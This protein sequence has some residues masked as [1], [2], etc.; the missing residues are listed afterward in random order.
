MNNNGPPGSCQGVLYDCRVFFTLTEYSSF[1]GAR[2]KRHT[3]KAPTYQHVIRCTALGTTVDTW[4]AE[5]RCPMNLQ[6]LS[7]SVLVI[8]VVTLLMILGYR[9][10]TGATDRETGKGSISSQ[11]CC[12]GK[13]ECG[14][15]K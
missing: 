11:S 5:R 10:K 7:T 15:K 2:T 9:V 12:G 13:S 4:C 1:D 6:T 14:V 8:A 3:T